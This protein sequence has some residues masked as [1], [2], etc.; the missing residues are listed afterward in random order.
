MSEIRGRHIVVTGGASG[1]GRLLVRA[2]AGLGGRVTV[3][4]VHAENLASTLAELAQLGPEKSHGFLCDV[5][6][7]ARVYEAATATTAAAGPVDVLVNN[8]GVVS[9]RA[10]L[11]IPDES[12]ERTFAIN[13]LS[14]FWVTKAF[15]PAM[16]ERNRGHIVT[17]ASA[18]ALIGV[19]RLTDYAA[20]KWAAM[21]FDESLRAELRQAAP[22]VMTTVVCPFYIDT[23]MFHGV[24]TRFPRLLPILQPDEVARRIV[25]SI[26]RDRRRLVMPPLIAT[27]P[28]MRMLPVRAFDWIANFLGVNASMDEFTGRG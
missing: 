25:D 21:G 22:G 1:L 20:S 11:D 8:A 3:W 28:L 7:R 24:K 12:I 9:G 2:L 19:A 6:N 26:R 23:G 13:T 10:L 27:V 18:S 5:S 14:L 15:L 16:I 4:D 17:I